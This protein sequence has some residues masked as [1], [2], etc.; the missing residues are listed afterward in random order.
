[1]RKKSSL[2]IIL[3]DINSYLQYNSEI[4]TQHIATIGNKNTR[5]DLALVRIFLHEGMYVNMYV[6]DCV[7]RYV[8]DWLAPLGVRG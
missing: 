7:C 6:G 8:A 3:K 5:R 1:M 2:P 4:R